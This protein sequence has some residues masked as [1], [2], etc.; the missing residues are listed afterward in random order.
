MVMF[1]FTHSII[2]AN[3]WIFN[4][5]TNVNC[6]LITMSGGFFTGLFENLLRKTNKKEVK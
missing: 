1:F 4:A 6:V 2:R 3:V 5:D